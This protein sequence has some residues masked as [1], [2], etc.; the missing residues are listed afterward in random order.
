MLWHPG[1]I[2]AEQ[3]LATLQGYARSFCMR[4]IHYRGTKQQPGLVL[5]LDHAKKAQ[6]KGMALR[7]DSDQAEKVLEELRARELISYAYL[8]KWLDVTL[9]GGA[10]V[11]AVT[12]V[13]NHDNTQYCHYDLE[14]QAHIIAKA[15]GTKGAN[16]E[17]LFNTTAKLHSLGIA[18]A[19]MDWLNKRV[20]ELTQGS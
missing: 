7:V 12:Y 10:R 19:D 20:Q 8:E 16:A 1:F 15:A 13:I 17:Y 4:S 2:P 18:D 14:T 3:H 5:A 9:E 11:N 6:C